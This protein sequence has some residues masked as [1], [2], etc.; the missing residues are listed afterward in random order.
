MGSRNRGDEAVATPIKTVCDYVH[1]NPVRAKL[2][3]PDQ[4]LSGY[5]WNSYREYL[6]PTRRRPE[7]SRVNRLLGSTAF[8]GI[9]K[10]G[11][12]LGGGWS[13]SVGRRKTPNS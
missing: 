7:W 11:V 5:Q 9:A 10:A 3:K 6:L 13:C 2:L 1:L 4:K 12:K 8:L